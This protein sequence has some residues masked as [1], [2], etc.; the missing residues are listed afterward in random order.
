MRNPSTILFV[1]LAGIAGVYGGAAADD[2]A[3][4][5]A[6]TATGG[7]E[8]F[9]GRTMKD[10][11]GVTV[12]WGVRAAAAVQRVVVV[13]AGYHGS[14]A[15]V[16]A[17]IGNDDATL[18]GSTFEAIARAT[19]MPGEPVQPYGFIGAGWRHFEVS[20]ATF[21]TADSGMRD[22]TDI[23]AVPVGAG[24]L[25]P[26]GRALADVRFTYRYGFDEALVLESG[27]AYAAMT[28]WTLD[29]GVGYR[30]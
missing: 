26:I 4:G 12:T 6:V 1:A 25:Y 29:A 28:T 21:T 30:F 15:S 16:H 13:E 8:E 2:R 5:F 3:S 27:G 14:A 10:T 24:I 7:V 23:V 22:A 11:S 20:G 9:V 19:P 18:V 17:P